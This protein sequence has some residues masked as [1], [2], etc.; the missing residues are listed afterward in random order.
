[1]GAPVLAVSGVSYF[2]GCD[3]LIS[4]VPSEE[5]WPK[6]EQRRVGRGWRF[7]YPSDP[8]LAEQI[9]SHL[10][11]LG[12]SLLYGDTEARAEGRAMLRDAARIRKAFGGT[13]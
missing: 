7:I 12:Q 2:G 5:K 6:P 9:A 3:P 4:S 8:V 13:Q 11:V 1:M 10:H